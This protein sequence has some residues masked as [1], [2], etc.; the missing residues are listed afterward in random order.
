MRQAELCDWALDPLLF[1]SLCDSLNRFFT[2][3][4]LF[5][6]TSGSPSM[7]APPATLSLPPS[8][9]PTLASLTNPSPL[10]YPPMT[11]PGSQNIRRSL[12]PQTQTQAFQRQ[13]LLQPA[14]NQHMSPKGRNVFC[15]KTPPV[16]WLYRLNIDQQLVKYQVQGI[17]RVIDLKDDKISHVIWLFVSVCLALSEMWGQINKFIFHLLLVQM[18]SIPWIT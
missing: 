12:T 11:G 5:D 1:T 4:G 8:A 15:V 7:L 17:N 3:K 6:S 13:S 14:P 18:H 16:G 2:Q 9:P 10:A